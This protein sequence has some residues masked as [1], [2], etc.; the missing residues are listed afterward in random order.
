M[1]DNP[2]YQQDLDQL[3]NVASLLQRATLCLPISPVGIGSSPLL[4]LNSMPIIA[5]RRFKNG[6]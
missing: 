4:S 1:K 3:R 6:N 2:I 5:N